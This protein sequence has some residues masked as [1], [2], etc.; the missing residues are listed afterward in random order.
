M[1]IQKDEARQVVG[2]RLR[3]AEKTHQRIA[4]EDENK[5][6]RGESDLVEEGVHWGAEHRNPE[7]STDAHVGNRMK[8]QKEGGARFIEFWHNLGA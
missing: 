8:P 2:H 5:Q 4:D 3:P 1:I 6:G 7:Y